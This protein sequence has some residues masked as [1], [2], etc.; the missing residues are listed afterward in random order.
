S[1][2]YRLSVPLAC[3]RANLRIF[4]PSIYFID[5]YLQIGYSMLR[6]ALCLA[7]PAIA[8]ASCTIRDGD[9]VTARIKMRN[10]ELDID[11]QNS[12]QQSGEWTAVAFGDDMSDL[13]IYLVE[14]KGTSVHAQSGFSKGYEPPTMD[15][16]GSMKLLDSSYTGG[17]THARF[18]RELAGTGP[19][20]HAL[21]SCATVSLAYGAMEGTGI[22]PHYERPNQTKVCFADC[23]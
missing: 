11:V 18:T 13:E 1:P 21:G 22:G 2:Y 9:G 8:L 5:R 3:D 4:L 14:L 12:K 6:L 20:K 7:L 17:T 10:G 19:R 16:S 15:G 23:K